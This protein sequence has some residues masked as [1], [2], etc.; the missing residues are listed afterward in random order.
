LAADLVRRHVAL[1]A[2]SGVPSAQAAKAATQT[3]PVLFSVGDDPVRHNLIATIAR[4]GGNVT[5][6]NFLSAE[7]GAKRLELLRLLV[8]EATRA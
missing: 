3:I 4:P 1:I 7:L 6:I 2:A 5:G 8:P